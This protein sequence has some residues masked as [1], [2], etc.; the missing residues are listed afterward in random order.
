MET[1]SIPRYIGS[2]ESAAS[3]DIILAGFP[4]DCTASY[5]PGSRFASR[6]IRAYSSEA[7]EEFSFY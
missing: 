7:I 2:L 1:L 3:A 5:R 4:Y 6:E